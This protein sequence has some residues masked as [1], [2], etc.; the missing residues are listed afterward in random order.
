MSFLDDITKVIERLPEGL[1]RAEDAIIGSFFDTFL[2][3]GFVIPT[4]S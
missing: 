2:F 3:N 1:H 4:R